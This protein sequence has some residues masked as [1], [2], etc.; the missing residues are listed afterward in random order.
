MT[1]LL[2]APERGTSLQDRLEEALL[3][4]INLVFLL[5]MF[6]LMAGHLSDEPLPGLPAGPNGGDRAPVRADLVITESG[7]FR[8]NGETLT[9]DALPGSLPAPAA[10]EPLRI[11]AAGQL[12]MTQL[13][14]L[15]A[16][17]EHLGY[18]DVMLL[19]EP[20]E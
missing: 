8:V 4:L 10:D 17:L 19:T 3:P 18:Q 7:H 11:A 14:P 1:P 6:F 13:E 15:L 5:L 12:A 9:A 16:E 2:P 20:A